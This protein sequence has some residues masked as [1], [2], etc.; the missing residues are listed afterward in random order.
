MTL[1]EKREGHPATA[2]SWRPLSL[3]TAGM[4]N[5]LPQ[6]RPRLVSVLEGGGRRGD[7]DGEGLGLTGACS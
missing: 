6:T 5:P 2:R 4:E 1:P 7:P 3:N